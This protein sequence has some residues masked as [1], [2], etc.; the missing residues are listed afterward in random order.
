M[1]KINVATLLK[2]SEDKTPILCLAK[3]PLSGYHD[4]PKH[5]HTHAF[6]TF[7]KISG[8]KLSEQSIDHFHT[9]FK[10]WSH[11]LSHD[12]KS[13]LMTG[14]ATNLILIKKLFPE[15]IDQIKDITTMSGAF[16]V[17]GNMYDINRPDFINE[18]AEFNV[19]LDVAAYDE[20][21]KISDIPITI[22]PL[23][24]T[25]YLLIEYSDTKLFSQGTKSSQFV[26]KS[27]EEAKEFIDKKY[28]FYW[29][30][31]ATVIFSGS[32]DI[33]QKWIYGDFK[34]N[35]MNAEA[36]DLKTNHPFD[37]LRPLSNKYKHYSYE[38]GGLTIEEKNANHS[39]RICTL[40][41]KDAFMDKFIKPL[42]K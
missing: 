21:T 26:Q 28:L 6:K 5:Y 8:T 42:K 36:K 24:A 18:D 22:V 31:L 39:H 14:P 30:Q 29:D 13:Y 16:Y 3:A 20:F 12:N 10:S 2:N 27:L 4:A 23:D 19:W 32:N 34:V 15:F 38:S 40:T 35:K 33:C 25:K 1:M 37:Q 11:E 9:D 41:N 17:P 7:E